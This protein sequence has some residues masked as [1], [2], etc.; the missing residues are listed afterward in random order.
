[1]EA[2]ADKGEQW[3]IQDVGNGG[4][5]IHPSQACGEACGGCEMKLSG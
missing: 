5:G 4:G 1:M 2:G 3:R